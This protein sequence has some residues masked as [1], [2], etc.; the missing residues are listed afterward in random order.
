MLNGWR[1][2]AAVAVV[3]A[4]TAHIPSGHVAVML[5]FVISGYCITAAAESCLQK[6]LSFRQFL[7]RR[8]RR[9]YPPYFFS[10]IFFILTRI[11][12]VTHGGT[13]QLDHPIIQWVQTFTLT[14]WLTLITHPG[15]YAFDNPALLVAAHWSL[16]YEEQFYVVMG[17][18]MVLVT[19][20]KL[21]LRWPIAVLLGCG[22]VWNCFFPHTS[23]GIFLEYWAHFGLGAV[24]FYRLCRPMNIW[25]CRGIDGLLLLTAAICGWL[26]WP[27]IWLPANR[28]VVQEF[29][30]VSSF[31][32]LLVLLRPLDNAFKKFPL[33]QPLLWLGSIT[34]SLYLIHQFNLNIMGSIAGRIIPASWPEFVSVS[35]QVALQIALTIPFW[36]LCERPFLNKNLPRKAERVPS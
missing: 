16:N 36:L 23:Y 5:F 33:A 3:V 18:L 30:V 29:F 17:L 25:L 6:G 24:V 14:Q 9:I 26:T 7:W 21:N 31:A 15:S 10:L 32:L 27:D 4:H 2:I 13:N 35:V 22:M 20:R 19:W 34:Y 12:K 28:S 8:V 11:V 1:G